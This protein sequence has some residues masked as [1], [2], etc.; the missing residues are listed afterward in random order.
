M[1]ELQ[2][3]PERQIRGREQPLRYLVTLLMLLQDHQVSAS[4][5][6]LIVVAVHP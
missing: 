5:P 3:T 6:Y 2:C 4:F 1:T